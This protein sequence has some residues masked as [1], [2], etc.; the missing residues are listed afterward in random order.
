MNW[1]KDYLTV[2]DADLLRGV[3][4]IY[5]KSFPLT[6]RRSFANIKASMQTGNCKVVTYHENGVVIGFILYWE[7]EEFIYIEFFATNPDRRNSGNGSVILR[8]FVAEHGAKPLILEIDEMNDEISKRRCG[9]YQREGFVLNHFVHRPSAY[10]D[11][12]VNLNMHIMTYGKEIT[13]KQYKDFNRLLTSKI[14]SNLY[15]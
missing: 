10:N 15:E 9:F 7:Y 14:M 1:K 5:L 3:W 12:S 13:E 11:M 8:D 6:E 2:N 4:D